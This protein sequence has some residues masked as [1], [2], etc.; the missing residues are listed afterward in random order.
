M[1]L[2]FF[3]LFNR[4]AT[5]FGGCFHVLDDK[6]NPKGCIIII[7]NLTFSNF[8]FKRAILDSAKLWSSL[9]PIPR[10]QP[11]FVVY[12]VEN[13]SIIQKIV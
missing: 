7:K 10:S 6:D 8:F 1:G 2:F 12:L 9:P 5:R 13:F 3:V 4:C 11:F